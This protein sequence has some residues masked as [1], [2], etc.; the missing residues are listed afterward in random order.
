MMAPARVLLAVVLAAAAAPEEVARV[1]PRSGPPAPASLDAFAVLAAVRATTVSNALAPAVWECFRKT[2]GRRDHGDCVYGWLVGA[3]A[4][5]GVVVEVGCHDGL[6]AIEA[7]EQG[8]DVFTFEPDPDHHAAAAAR[9]D[10]WRATR[11]GAA[12]AVTLARY[13]LGDAPGALNF[14]KQG[15]DSHV[16]VGGPAAD[17]A[18]WTAG[19][20]AAGRTTVNVTTI[21]DLAAA[22]ALGDRGNGLILKIDTQGFD[23]NVLLGAHATLAA[24][25]FPFV[26]TEYWPL[27]SKR[28]ARS[29]ATPALFLLKAAGYAIYNLNYQ[30]GPTSVPFYARG[31]RT[32]PSIAGTRSTPP[33]A[34][35]GPRRSARPCPTSRR[36]TAGS[37]SSRTTWAR[38]VYEKRPRSTRWAAPWTYSPSIPPSSSTSPRSSPPGP[39]PTPP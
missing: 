37:P 24:G 26:M 2:S 27:A 18:E 19:A 14:I 36:R 25:A 23:V 7:A 31:R 11:G 9:I 6:Q 15:S 12:G 8:H 32:D 3:L 38:S 35:A 28:R 29:N 33:R 5:G 20:K 16:D 22:G 39:G 10:A 34:F 21:D 17:G 30:S 1:V 4:P 13:G